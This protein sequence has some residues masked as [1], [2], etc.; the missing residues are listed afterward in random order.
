MN[1]LLYAKVGAA[2]VLLAVVFYLGGLGPKAALERDHAA[3][4]QAATQAL[5]A[6]RAQASAD[7]AHL[8][9][10]IDRYDAQKDIPNPVDTGLAHRVYITAASGCPVPETRIVAGGIEAPAALA[11][12][13]PGIVGRLQDLIDACR[14]DAEQMSAM[15][16]LAP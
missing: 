8:Q 3:M 6:Q 1:P 15:I 2:V 16:Q 9:G 12:S 7:H 5:L 10:V 13:D 14:D 4:A 11:G